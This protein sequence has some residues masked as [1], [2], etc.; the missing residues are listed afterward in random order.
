MLPCDCCP[1]ID[2]FTAADDLDSE[3]LELAARGGSL[4]GLSQYVALEGEIGC[5][6]RMTADLRALIAA[7]RHAGQER[8][9]QLVATADRCNPAVFCHGCN[10]GGPGRPAECDPGCPCLPKRRAAVLGAAAAAAAAELDHLELSHARQVVADA[11]WRRLELA[12]A[13]EGAYAVP[14]AAPW[15]PPWLP[16]SN[17]YPHASAAHTLRSRAQRGHLLGSG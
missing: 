4:L 13:V 7:D 17:L 10:A 14:Q 1:E 6:V 16:W 12:Q 11:V 8:I 2:C 15:R 5:V 9:W 3:A